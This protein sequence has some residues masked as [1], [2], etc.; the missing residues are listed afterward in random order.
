MEDTLPTNPVRIDAWVWAVRLVKTRSQAIQA[1]KA[2]HIKLA[3]K[4]VKASQSITPGDRVRVWV[5]H[6]EYDVE[7]VHTIKKRVG[8][9]IARS[10][11]VDHSPPP[12]PREIIMSM[13]RRDRG[14]GRPTK[15][16]RRE[17]DRLRG[18][19]EHF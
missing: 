2:G 8:A 1:C 16:E 3:G 15:K 14:A 6:R 13:P 19:R 11:Y 18:R 4:A 10:C 5:D 17:I 9:Q 12:V 7:V